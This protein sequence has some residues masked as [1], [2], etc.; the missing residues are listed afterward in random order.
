MITAWRLRSAVWRSTRFRSVEIGK[1]SRAT[2]ILA[3]GPISGAAGAALK[4][5]MCKRVIGGGSTRPANSRLS[6]AGTEP[7]K[8]TRAPELCPRISAASGINNLEPPC[9]F[10]ASESSS[11]TMI[12]PKSGNG[13]NNA[14][15]VPNSTEIR[16]VALLRQTASRSSGRKPPCS[17][18]LFATPPKASHA[19]SSRLWS[20]ARYKIL[21]PSLT[22]RR[23]ASATIPKRRLGL[24]PCSRIVAS[25]SS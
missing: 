25:D 12:K 7:T 17:M 9:S 20:G 6:A 24:P 1:E 14:I 3:S 18:A 16:P 5:T 10:H 23:I 21:C 15:G 4:S 2:G 11:S 13:A 22:A 19:R 8:S